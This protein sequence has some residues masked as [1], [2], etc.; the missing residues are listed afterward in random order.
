MHSQWNSNGLQFVERRSVSADRS[1]V[2]ASGTADRG[3]F[4]EFR[5]VKPGPVKPGPVKPGPVKPGPVKPGIAPCNFPFP[6]IP[7]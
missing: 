5:R 2:Q 3:I 6:A 7:S 1:Q 4:A